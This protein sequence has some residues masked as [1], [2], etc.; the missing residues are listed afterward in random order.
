MG[1]CLLARSITYGALRDRTSVCAVTTPVS[2]ADVDSATPG[3]APAAAP[4]TP[5]PASPAIE[6]NKKTPPKSSNSATA[7]KEDDEDDP[8]SEDIPMEQPWDYWPYRV[9]IW[10]S[11]NHERSSAARLSKPLHDYLDR[12][13]MSVWQMTISDAPSP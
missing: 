11:S 6:A 4:E 12:S 5:A 13:F 1:P 7:N 8:S 10:L 2:A 3:Q 9:K